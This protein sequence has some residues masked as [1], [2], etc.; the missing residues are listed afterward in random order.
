M[1]NSDKL[2]ITLETVVETSISE[3]IITETAITEDIS[4]HIA[5][6]DRLLVDI[7]K[8]LI[9]SE[10]L[11][12]KYAWVIE[13]DNIV[14]IQRILSLAPNF[15]TEIETSITQIVKDRK[16]NADDMPDLISLVKKIYQVIYEIKN[17]KMTAL[18]IA[19]VTSRILKLVVRI[20]V[21]ERK[22]NID[23]EEEDIFFKQTDMLIL[24]CVSLL[25]FPKT[26]KPKGCWK[27]FLGCF[28]C[29]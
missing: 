24:S 27:A 26:I 22:I 11:K 10:K 21:E 15:F 2:D 14:I 8:E 20:L 5:P 7:V 28:S 18:K 25:S 23:K 9:D 19:D 3:T 16:I 4:N 1:E 6:I 13:E 17:V 12:E 29:K